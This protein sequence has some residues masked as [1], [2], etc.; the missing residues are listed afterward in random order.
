MFPGEPQ[1]L[2]QQMQRAGVVSAG[3][4]VSHEELP[5]VQRLHHSSSFPREAK[6]QKH[7][8][9]PEVSASGA[10]SKQPKALA[11][12][13]TQNGFRGHAEAQSPR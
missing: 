3:P 5:T 11:W 2:S 10:L 1:R 13:V 4:Q 9:P 6:S 8:L 12:E 7:R